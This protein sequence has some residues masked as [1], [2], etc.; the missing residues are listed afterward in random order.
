[1]SGD[2]PSRRRL[3]LGATLLPIVGGCSATTP[4][5]FYTLSSRPG[6]QAASAPGTV[7]VKSV[8]LAKYLDRP[9]IVRRGGGQQLDISEFDRWPEDAH[10][11]VTRVMVENLSIR[12][13]QSQ[14]FAGSGPLT[15][16]A[17]VTIESEIRRFDPDPD[18][19]VV[20][21]ANWLVQGERKN[22][23][24]QSEV[25]RVK[26]DSNDTSALVVAMSD[27]L[28]QLADR[29]AATTAQAEVPKPSTSPRA[30]ERGSSS[31]SAASR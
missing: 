15:M 12:L 30:A 20:L 17:D 21:A 11:M 26:S 27:A 2:L 6:A 10:D 24:L 16:N 8:E 14:V 28:A 25:I 3:I 4:S 31:R 29:I 18:G 13:P 19:T 9:Q 5:K 1:M 22:A 7:M 23:R